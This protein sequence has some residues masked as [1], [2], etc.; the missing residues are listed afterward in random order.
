MLPRIMRVALKI[1]PGPSPDCPGCAAL[2]S[3]GTGTSP[4]AGGFSWGRVP[5]LRGRTIRSFGESASGWGELLRESPRHARA[6]ARVTAVAEDTAAQ[7]A[8]D[9]EMELRRV[10]SRLADA[11][12]AATAARPRSSPQRPGP[13]RQ[14]ASQSARPTIRHQAASSRLDRGAPHAAAAIARR[15]ETGHRLA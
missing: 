10:K 5:L 4:A 8:R 12:T 15:G 1:R 7:T 2:G 14:R 11:E 6:V 13:R 9:A 3:F